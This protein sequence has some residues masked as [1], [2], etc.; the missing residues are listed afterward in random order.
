MLARFRSFSLAGGGALALTVMLSGVV[1]AAT[2]LAVVAAPAPAAP[3]AGTAA[4]FVDLDGN[5]VDDRCQTAVVADPVAAASAEIAADLNADG[6]IS[7][8]EAAQS[9]RVGGTNCNHGGYVSTVAHGTCAAPATA[10]S[11]TAPDPEAETSD[12]STEP[13]AANDAADLSCAETAASADPGEADKAIK[14][15]TPAVCVAPVVTTPAAP[16]VSVIV[17]PAPNAH[18]K[19]VS[20]V[21]QSDAVGGKNCNHGGAVSAAAKKDHDAAKSA[22]DVAKAARDAARAARKAAHAAKHHGKPAG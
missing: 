3:V 22:R 6:A 18:G 15:E 1:A 10:D 12:A 21:A 2:V 17:D 5:G 8:T 9:G 20:L 4:S 14:D 19:A 13:V 16:V 11:S 7:V